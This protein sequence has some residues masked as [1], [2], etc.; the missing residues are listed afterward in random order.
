MGKVLKCIS[1]IVI[2]MTLSK[3]QISTMELI[4]DLCDRFGDDRWFVQVELLGVTKHTMD[5]L[6]SKGFLLRMDVCGM[7]YYRLIKRSE[8]DEYE[9]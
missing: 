3:K 9:K 1:S 6:V 2:N 7:P 5:A 8:S 4:G